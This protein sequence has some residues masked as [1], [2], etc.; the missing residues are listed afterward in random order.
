M[1]LQGL[2]GGTYFPY[3]EQRNPSFLV[4]VS[5]LSS[6]RVAR[7][8]QQIDLSGIEVNS[9]RLSHHFFLAGATLVLIVQPSAAGPGIHSMRFSR[10]VSHAVVALT[11]LE[12]LSGHGARPLDL[13]PILGSDARHIERS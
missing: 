7:D 8:P 2:T 13:D 12:A 1:R 10:S 5:L 6:P 9:G 11:E 4:V 3:G